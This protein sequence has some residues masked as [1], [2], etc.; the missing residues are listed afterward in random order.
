VATLEHPYLLMAP[1]RRHAMHVNVVP[2]LHATARPHYVSGKKQ[3]SMV[4]GPGYT[5]QSLHL[6]HSHNMA[7]TSHV[8]LYA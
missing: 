3:I 8:Q 5:W 2:D 6:L 4:A 7:P 1:R